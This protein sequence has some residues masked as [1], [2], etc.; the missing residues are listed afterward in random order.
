MA[1]SKIFK[2]KLSIAYLL[3]VIS[4]ML[5][6]ID[7]A[8]NDFLGFYN[9]FVLNIRERLS[10]FPFPTFTFRLWIFGLSLLI[11]ILFSITVFIYG[12]NKVILLIIR[13]FSFLMILNGLGHIIGS[14][15]FSEILPGFYFSPLLIGASIYL[16]VTVNSHLRISKKFTQ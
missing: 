13:I 1:V 11:I 5:H 8:V 6:I 15:Y 10:F 14:I 4:L 9:P 2:D 3:F 12:R 16:M 7:E